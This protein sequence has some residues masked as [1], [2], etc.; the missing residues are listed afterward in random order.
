MLLDLQN[1]LKPFCEKY[2]S[3]CASI[4]KTEEDNVII[5]ICSPASKKIQNHDNE[6]LK[7]DNNSNFSV[8]QGI[9]T[10]NVESYTNQ[11]QLT[12]ELHSQSIRHCQEGLRAVFD[13][14]VSKVECDPHTFL[15]PI[16]EFIHNYQSTKKGELVS[17][18]KTFSQ[19]SEIAM[20][21]ARTVKC[22]QSGE[23][24]RV[25]DELTTIICPKKR[26]GNR[27]KLIRARPLFQS[28]SQEPNNDFNGELPAL[29]IVTEDVASHELSHHEISAVHN[30][31]SGH[32]ISMVHDVT[33]HT[34]S[35]PDLHLHPTHLT[36]CADQQ[37]RV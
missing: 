13:D 1:H 11:S 14:L 23:E 27:R 36:M 2:E 4:E 34:P 9:Q 30:N 5:A 37:R 21:V 17:A 8:P 35:H 31:I 33:A 10:L 29:Q 16:N 15:R 32:G 3:H 19:C 26:K 12:S 7:N 25:K 22:Q 18:L 6:N 28:A 24:G 20:A